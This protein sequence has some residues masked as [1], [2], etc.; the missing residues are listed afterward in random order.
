LGRH[1]FIDSHDHSTEKIPL[2]TYCLSR[3]RGGPGYLMLS[4]I[5]GRQWKT[6]QLF[7]TGLVASPEN[8]QEP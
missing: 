1:S 3:P 2:F 7:G 8:L 4:D 5:L 6:R